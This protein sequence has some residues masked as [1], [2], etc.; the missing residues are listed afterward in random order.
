[1][2]NA[3]VCGTSLCGFNSHQAPLREHGVGWSARMSEEHEVTVRF[4]VFPLESIT[5][6]KCLISVTV[7]LR[8]PKPSLKVQIFHQVPH[9]HR[10]SKRMASTVNRKLLGALPRMGVVPVFQLAQTPL[11]SPGKC[12]I[13]KGWLREVPV[14]EPNP[15]L[16][17]IIMPQ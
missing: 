13:L 10:P 2:V 1:M 8:S 17:S 3:L 16:L 11:L 12:G 9:S 6:Y 7:T 15:L 5:L 14:M 4:C